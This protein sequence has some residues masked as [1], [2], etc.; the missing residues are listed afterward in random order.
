MVDTVPELSFAFPG[1]TLSAEITGAAPRALSVTNPAM[2][3]V[4][5]GEC[6]KQEVTFTPALT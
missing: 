1:L 3:L 2:D 4:N 5:F 6:A